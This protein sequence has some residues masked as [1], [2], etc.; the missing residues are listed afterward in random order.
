M[1][2]TSSS[3]TRRG[4]LAGR[5][6]VVAF[7]QLPG[8]L[9]AAVEDNAIGSFRV[10]VPEEALVDLRRRI[11]ATRWPDRETVT[12]RSQGA[13]L[14]SRCFPARSIRRHEAGSSAV[15]TSS[16]ISTRSTRAVTSRRGNSRNCSEP[17]SEQRSDRCANQYETNGARVVRA[18]FPGPHTARS[19]S[20][21]TWLEPSLSSF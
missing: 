14:P 8:E 5:A 12:D 1:S 15:I 9:H 20:R 6:A 16:S 18:V 2:T 17:N 19:M 10:I 7:G 11:A 4:L 13:Q 3:P 21:S